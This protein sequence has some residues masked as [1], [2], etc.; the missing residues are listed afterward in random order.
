MTD[1]TTVYLNGKIWNRNSETTLEQQ[2]THIIEIYPQE[3]LVDCPSKTYEFTTVKPTMQL[4]VA[5]S[6]NI[7]VGGTITI[8]AY[9]VTSKES[10]PANVIING[11]P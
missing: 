5:P 9:D 8:I 1:R 10:I 11:I 6:P 7:E 4:Q 2:G 3:D